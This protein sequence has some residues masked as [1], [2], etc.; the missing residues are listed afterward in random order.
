MFKQVL[1]D[2]WES[3][4]PV[5]QQHYGITD[6]ESIT[7][8]GE[9]SVRHG[10]FIKFLMPL[11]RLTGA[12]IP[13]EGDRFEVIVENKRV[14]DVMYWHRSF[15]KDNKVYEFKSKMQKFENNIVEFVGL[16]IGVKM[17]LKV[18]DGR[19]IYEDKG[20]V[21]KLR[22]RLYS[23]PIHL[24]VGKSEIEEFVDINDEHDFKM[25]FVMTHPLFGFAF[26][27]MGYMNIEN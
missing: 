14:G 25:R 4:N 19:L 21:I 23:V 24:L 6:G 15:K 2:Q 12:L 10:K 18:D 1:A 22:K 27:Y 20:Y 26:S 9:L 8:R 3:L 7:M 5:L 13:V 17:G 11:I 16:G